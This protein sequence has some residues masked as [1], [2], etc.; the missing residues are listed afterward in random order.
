MEYVVLGCL[1]GGFCP[2]C[3]IPKDAMGHESGI[4]QT[5]D[6][7]PRCDK[8]RYSV[9]RSPGTRNASETIVYSRK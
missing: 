2:L 6:E 5:D 8:L 9:L 3:E 4:L 1:I 7:Y